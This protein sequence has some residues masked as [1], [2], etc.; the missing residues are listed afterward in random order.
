MPFGGGLG[1]DALFGIVGANSGF[2]ADLRDASSVVSSGLGLF[3][4]SATAATAPATTARVNAN[5]HTARLRRGSFASG[6]VALR[7][8]D[9]ID[10]ATRLSVN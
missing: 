6:A 5:A 2:V 10:M 4:S 8:F 9:F 7:F 3:R 1:D